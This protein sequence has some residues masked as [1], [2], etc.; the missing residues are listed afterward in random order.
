MGNS[1]RLN[2]AAIREFRRHIREIEREVEFQL[3]DQTDCCGVTMAQCHVLMEIDDMGETSIVDLAKRLRLD[4]STL[5]RTVD[6][7]VREG[8]VAREINPSNRR[9]VVIGLTDKGSAKASEIN[10]VCDRFYRGILKDMPDGQEY[11]LESVR[12]LSEVLNRSNSVTCCG[13]ENG[14]KR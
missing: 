12:R 2:K 4:T 3:K 11:F 1:E 8:Y 6:G 7:L 9:F 14:A 5:S 13:V 10:E